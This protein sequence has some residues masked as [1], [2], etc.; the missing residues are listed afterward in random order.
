MHATLLTVLLVTG[1]PAPAIS[2]Q[3]Q[4]AVIVEDCDCGAYQENGCGCSGGCGRVRGDVAW[5]CP[6]NCLGPMPQT[7]YAPRFGC[8]PGN[9]RC[10][11]R[12]P[13]FH[14]YY[15]RQVYNY[16]QLF[17]YP[18]HATPHEPEGFYIYPTSRQTSEGEEIIT[19]HPEQGSTLSESLPPV[20]D[21]P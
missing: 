12:Y 10:M 8:Y 20:G 13:A 14:G 3:Q 18:W 2:A 19:P 4:P 1:A 15:Y 17:D 5:G 21:L 6:R 11:H 7:C 16:R 9:N